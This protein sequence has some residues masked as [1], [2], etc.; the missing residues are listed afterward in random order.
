VGAWVSL[1]AA[2]CLVSEYF[3]AGRTIGGRSRVGSPAESPGRVV[4]P[5]P[6]LMVG[7]AFP[8]FVALL[9]TLRRL[10]LFQHGGAGAKAY[11]CIFNLGLGESPAG[12]R[13]VDV[14]RPAAGRFFSAPSR[15]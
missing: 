1:V 4:A 3:V 7:A 6:G 14:P 2:P 10:N 9:T 11:L 12:C 13:G 8:P 15:D 5:R